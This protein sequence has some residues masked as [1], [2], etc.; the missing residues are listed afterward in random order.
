MKENPV[1]TKKK[2][3]VTILDYRS[4][5]FE[6]DSS[7]ISSEESEREAPNK[8]KKQVLS[9]SDEENSCYISDCSSLKK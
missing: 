7:S 1:G 3:T 6:G 4:P 8:K 9:E 2:K 5:T